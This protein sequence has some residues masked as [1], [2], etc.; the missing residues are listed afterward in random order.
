MGLQHALKLGYKRI[1]TVSTGNMA[2]AVPIA[3]VKKLKETGVLSDDDRVVC[4][5]TGSGLKYTA[6][7]AKHYMKSEECRLEDLGEFIAKNY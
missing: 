2:S 1:G 4:I 7:F 3:A 5:I 6:A